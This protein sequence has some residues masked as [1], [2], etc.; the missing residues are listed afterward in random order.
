MNNTLNNH[1]EIK[2]KGKPD[3]TTLYD[4]LMQVK[5]ATEKFAE[6]LGLNIL[7]AGLGAILHDIGKVAQIFQERLNP[8]YIHTENEEPYRH[9]IAS[10]FFLSLFDK[11]IHPQLIEMILSHHKSIVNDRRMRGLFDLI[12]EY[13]IDKVFELHSKD[14]ETWSL[15]ALDILECFDIKVRPITLEEAKNNLLEVIEYCK[16][17][18]IGV[19]DYSD[20]RGILMG[21][22]HFASALLSSTQEFLKPT[23]KIPNLSYYHNRKKSKFYPLSL[24]KSDSKK[25][26]TMVVAPTGSAKTDF[27]LRRCTSRVFYTLPFTAS[28]NA[29]FLR[30]LNETKKENNY[31]DVND[32]NYIDI[33]V[34][35]SSSRLQEKRGIRELKLIQSK[36][37]ASIK[38]LTPHQMACIAFGTNGY[39][40]ILLD[41]KGCDVI[42]DE[43]HTYNDKIQGI[44]LKIIEMLSSIGCKIHIGTAT[45]STV[46][47]NKILEILGGKENVYEIRL[48]RKEM[49]LYDRHKIFKHPALD[50]KMFSVIKKALKNNEKV[51]IVRNRVAH[52]QQTYIEMKAMFPE[53]PILLLHSRFKRGTRNE[54][55]ELLMKWNKK[56]NKACI[57]VST[58][59]VEVSLDI[60]FDLMITDCAPIESLLQRFGRIN[61][62]RTFKTIGKYK[63][64]YVLAPPADRKDAMPYQLNILQKTYEILPD[65]KILR[66][67]TIQKLIDTVHPTLNVI[68]IDAASIFENGEFNSLFKLQNQA[69]SVLFEEL[70][71]MSTN[72]I[73]DIDV[74]EYMTANTERRTMLEI[75]VIYYSIQKLEL[76]QLKDLS[77]RPFIISSDVYNDEIGL[78]MEM[79]KI[80]GDNTIL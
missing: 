76:A 55:E 10:L 40:A 16:K 14:F 33:S 45:L 37:G 65:R 51:L 78:D 2:A 79:L 4:H 57:V 3:F 25:L 66:E 35:H 61:R 18:I 75:P 47:Y 42:L 6:H 41:L 77:H 49:R 5:L 36:F 31:I 7:I 28:I 60:S 19:Y 74:E 58:Q 13:G 34:L 69:K 48:T 20:W 39:E 15:T 12:E 80:F 67:H 50:A 68:S 43:I 22:D 32:K 30:I 46:L 53:I 8:D 9:E 70:G 59:V 11:E 23:F 62:I 64:I 44:V 29:M 73:L 17:N 54:R 52:S 38:V 63:R 27:L 26:H 1:V 21:G 72:V 71:I 56:R 24:R